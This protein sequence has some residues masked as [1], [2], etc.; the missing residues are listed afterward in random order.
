MSQER[1]DCLNACGDDPWLATGKAEPCPHLVARA[2]AEREA[3]AKR[4]RDAR[5]LAASGPLLAACVVAEAFMAGFEDD[6]TQ[7]GVP[8]ALLVIRGAIAQA[9]PNGE[10]TCSNAA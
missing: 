5:M 3:Q 6:T 4:V 8:A 1:C 2:A 9:L 7:P 10:T